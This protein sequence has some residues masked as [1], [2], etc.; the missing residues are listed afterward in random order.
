MARTIAQ[1]QQSIIDSKNA[2]ATLSALSSSSNVAI[3]KLW[4]YIVAVCQWVLE[5]LFDLHKSEVTAIIAAQKPHT[6]Q[7]YVT[8]AKAFQYG[9]ILPPDTDVHEAIDDPTVAAEMPLIN[10][11][12]DP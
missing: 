12:P 1:I 4:S 6:L 11:V 7:W 10:T 9:I 8:K 5:N 2:D 3:W